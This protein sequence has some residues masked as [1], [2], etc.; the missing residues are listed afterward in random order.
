MGTAPRVCVS[1]CV[2]A[3]E[4]KLNQRGTGRIQGAAVL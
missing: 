2:C 4:L 3:F 1:V